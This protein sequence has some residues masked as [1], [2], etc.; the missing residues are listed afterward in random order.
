MRETQCGNRNNTELG[1]SRALLFG[2]GVFFEPNYT[3][4][5]F[6]WSAGYER[7]QGP[8]A[9]SSYVKPGKLRYKSEETDLS[10]TQPHFSVIFF[11]YHRGVDS[12]QQICPHL[13]FHV[14]D[15]YVKS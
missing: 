13:L 3:A 7:I 4:V 9:V 2:L 5:G 8:V 1:T 12:L 6:L 14:K 10:E 15:H 11:I